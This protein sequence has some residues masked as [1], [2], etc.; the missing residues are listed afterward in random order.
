MIEYRLRGS[1]EDTAAMGV[2]GLVRLVNNADLLC[3]AYLAGIS[4]LGRRVRIAVCEPA[5]PGNT[6]KV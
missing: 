2:A 6:G 4:G 3:A 5:N 1:N